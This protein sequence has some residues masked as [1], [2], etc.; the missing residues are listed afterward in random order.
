MAHAP[1]YEVCEPHTLL[2]IKKMITKVYKLIRDD[3]HSGAC[4]G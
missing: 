2:G 3:S 4:G 1:P